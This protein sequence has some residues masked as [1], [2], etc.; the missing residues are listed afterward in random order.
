MRLLATRRLIA[1]VSCLALAAPGL[2]RADCAKAY[3]IPFDV[4]LYVPERESTIELRAFEKRSISIAAAEALN[5]SRFPS[6][7]A[8]QYRQGDTRALVRVRGEDIYIDRSG[9]I[10]QGTRYGKAALAEIERQLSTPCSEPKVPAPNTLDMGAGL[11]CD[12]AH[13]ANCL[14][15][16]SQVG[17]PH[18][19]HIRSQLLNMH[20]HRP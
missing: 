14:W 18:D 13:A 6:P 7:D 5:P 1:A 11:P 10:R 12:G 19:L 17:L 8:P 15:L 2:S 16:I 4:E 9:W 20:L 3:S